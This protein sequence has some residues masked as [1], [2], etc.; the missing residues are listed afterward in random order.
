MTFPRV[1]MLHYE[2]IWPT[3]I[4]LGGPKKHNGSHEQTAL[5]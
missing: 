2:V 4:V 5:L 1:H 3:V